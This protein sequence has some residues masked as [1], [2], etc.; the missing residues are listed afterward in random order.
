MLKEWGNILQFSKTMDEEG[1]FQ[2]PR[3]LIET[4]QQSK[5]VKVEEIMIH[6]KKF[7]YQLV[8]CEDKSWE[9]ALSSIR[10]GGDFGTDGLGLSHSDDLRASPQMVAKVLSHSDSK[11][12]DGGGGLNLEVD[13]LSPLSKL[14]VRIVTH[15]EGSIEKSEESNSLV[16]PITPCKDLTLMKNAEDEN[17]SGWKWDTREED[18]SFSNSPKSLLSHG[19]AI[20][21]LSDSSI[22]KN[23][24]VADSIAVNWL[25][26][27]EVVNEA[28]AILETGLHMGLIM[29]NDKASSLNLIKENLQV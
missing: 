7:Q 12:K 18:N 23:L 4:R 29:V 15:S 20:N 16:N 10:V 9:H 8:E 14:N 13:S 22:L 11:S 27:G 3:F 25:N 28:E 24:G 17:D 5:L 19:E 21:C 1:F 2:N 6:N 26:F